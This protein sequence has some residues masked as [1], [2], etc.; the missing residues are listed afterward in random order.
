MNKIVIIG[1]GSGM[2]SKKLICD[3][4]TYDD[5]HIDA[6][7]LVDINEHK[8]HVME[9]VANKIVKQLGKNTVI[10]AST[11]RRN[12]LKDAKYVINTIGVGGVELY[13]KD[14]QIPEK[15]GCIQ[16]VGDI[17]GPGGMFRGLRAFPAI[18]G[19]CKDM[20]ELCPD[21]YFFN[22]TNPMAALCLAL[23]K[24][25]KIKVFGFCHNVQSTALQ[26]SAYLGTTMDHVSFWAA[27]INHMDWF[28][29]Y[30]VDGKDAY[31]E[32]FEIAKDWKRIEEL[33]KV[34]PDYCHYDAKVYDFVRF[35]I[36]QNFGKYVSESPFHMGEY[37]PYFR[38]NEEMIKEYKIEDRWWLRQEQGRDEY[39]EELEALIRENKEIP[40]S[41]SFEYAP[42]IIHANLAGKP[43]RANL[44]VP[45]TGL[46]TNLSNDS[47]VEV[48]C[49][50]D[51]EGI[52]PCYVGEIPTQLA[53]LNTSNIVVHQMMAKAMVEKKY[54]YIYEG[55]KL[56]PMTAANCT[57]KQITSMVDELIEVNKAYLEG[58][59]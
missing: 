13:E 51:S 16:N 30:K 2:F 8:L 20:E 52:H 59:K 10:E 40:I 11:E 45:N 37:C 53:A 6:I 3:V 17:I 43:F 42:E 41:K 58:F 4:L 19:M 1:A 18:L 31:P 5:M 56:D 23:S 44:N 33:Q 50:A 57:L 29:Q 24:A 25:T 36:M 27:G 38:K 49:Y 22:Y 32:L 12:V 21:A 34:E 7:G 35:E 54:E 9:Q 48:P 28:L 55:V 26:L 15:Y 47:V 39:F 46:I 14:L